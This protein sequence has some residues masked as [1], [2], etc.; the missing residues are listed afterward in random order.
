MCGIAGFVSGSRDREDIR[1]MIEAVKH[2]GPDASGT[3]FDYCHNVNVALGHRRLSIIDVSESANQPFESADGRYVITY[4]GEV[5]NFRE[6]KFKYNIHT[7]TQSDTEVVLEL[8]ARYGEK[9]IPEFNGMFSAVI[10]DRIFNKLYAFRDRYGIKPFFYYWNDKEFVFASEL[11]SITRII[12]NEIHI[13]KDSI[14]YYLNMGFIPY[15]ISVY[16]NVYKLPPGFFLEFDVTRMYLNTKM[17]YALSN[18]I[19][20]TTISNVSEIENKLEE[21]L[22]KAVER[23][24]ISDVPV[25]IFLSGGIDSSLLAAIARRLS[26][27]RVVTF[28]LGFSNSLFNEEAYASEVAKYLNAEHHVFIVNDKDFT[29]RL[30]EML[31]LYDE[32]YIISAGFS[33]YLLSSFTSKYVKV[34]LT[35]EGAD[36]TFLGYNFYNWAYRFEKYKL[37]L[38]QRFLYCAMK[39]H[40]NS[41]Y[42]L[43]AELFNSS[44]NP[45]ERRI[46]CIEQ[47]YFT[48][49]EIKKY[50]SPDIISSDF[51]FA[52]L[53]ITTPRPLNFVEKQSWYDIHK[54]LVDDLLVKTDRST[55]AHSLEARVPYLDN[56]LFD[57]V[58]NIDANLRGSNGFNKTLLRNILKKYLPEEL[59]MRRK[60]GFAPPLSRW[61]HSELREIVDKYL[62]D[63]VIR[64]YGLVDI[65]YVNNLKNSFFRGHSHLFNKIWLLALLHRWLKMNV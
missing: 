12:K 37:L 19:K 8:F 40:P 51:S 48:D 34:V 49:E 1:V 59:F 58:V 38:W 16:R 44:L 54:Y 62:N 35:G 56:E 61:L 33:V 63:D 23:Q 60:W 27:D 17:Y 3:Y 15:P 53:D 65:I 10:Y 39:L 30:D 31:D 52:G 36:E 57:Y 45:I 47:Y 6:L 64:E 20:K 4:N 18:S 28:T 2:R 41:Y 32:P 50:F 13:N 21:L 5:Y 22:N 11:K 9:I 14:S 55:M 42:R 7:R 24:M 26:S 43:K 46:F 25:G 29:D